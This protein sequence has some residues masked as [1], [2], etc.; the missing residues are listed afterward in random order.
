MKTTWNHTGGIPYS[1]QK[2]LKQMEGLSSLGGFVK[3]AVDEMVENTINAYFP[4]EVISIVEKYCPIG[5]DFIDVAEKVLKNENDYDK[6]AIQG[7]DEDGD[8]I[9]RK[10]NQDFDNWAIDQIARCEYLKIKNQDQGL[11]ERMEGGRKIKSAFRRFNA[12][13]ERVFRLLYGIGEDR[14]LTVRQIAALPEFNCPE[15]YISIIV[16]DINRTIND[17]RCNDDFMKKVILKQI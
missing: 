15:R 11:W 3:E 13:D 2:N 8:V 10:N 6:Y 12:L 1:T 5:M 16:D 14:K 9:V 4:D 7:F 17:K